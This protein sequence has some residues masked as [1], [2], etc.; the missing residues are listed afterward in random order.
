CIHTAHYDWKLATERGKEIVEED[1]SPEER[2]NLLQLAYRENGRMQVLSTAPQ[3]AMVAQILSGGN[4]A[5]I[6]THFYNVSYGDP[7]IRRLAVFIGGCGAGRFYISVE[8]NGDLYPCVFFSHDEE[9]RLGN[10]LKDDFEE[11]WVENKLLWKLRNKDALKG[12]CGECL[13]RYICGGCR[14]RAY[15]YFHDVLAPDPGCIYNLGKWN[16]LKASTKVVVD[17]QTMKT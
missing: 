13:Y 7:N 4:P 10:L 15:N 1:L 2:L 8:P 6:P 16:E 12:N 14:A 3:Y 17:L 11:I 5:I 9:V